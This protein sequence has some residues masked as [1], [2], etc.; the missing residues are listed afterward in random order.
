MFQIFILTINFKFFGLSGWIRLVT[1][2][3]PISIV[4]PYKIYL[5]IFI[6]DW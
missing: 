1:L 2:R 3:I 4:T 6:S 5:G